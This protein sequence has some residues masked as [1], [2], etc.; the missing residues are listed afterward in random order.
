M[1]NNAVD[2][3]FTLHP[4]A[5]DIAS[6]YNGLV[7]FNSPHFQDLN[8][9]QFGAFVRDENGDIVGGLTGRIFDSALQINY[10]WL[11]DSIRSQGVGTALLEK[12]ELEAKALDIATL[13]VDTYSF[14]APDFYGKLGFVEMGRY[15]NYPKSGIDKIFFHKNI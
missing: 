4:E 11:S 8:E 9:I 12:V 15:V 5:S 1:K 3:Y 6:I 2:V 13:C 14:Q 7:S 10:L